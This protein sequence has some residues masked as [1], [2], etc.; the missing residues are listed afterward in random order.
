MIL[1]RCRVEKNKGF[2]NLIEEKKIWAAETLQENIWKS[3][4]IF[5]SPQLMPRV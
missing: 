5:V 1:N 4:P 3:L 2:S